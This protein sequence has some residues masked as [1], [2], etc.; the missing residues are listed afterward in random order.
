M[1]INDTIHSYWNNRAEGYSRRNRDEL[2]GQQG[3]ALE[4]LFADNLHPQPGA[5]ALDVGCGPGIFAITLAKLGCSVTGLDLSEEMLARAKANASDLGLS[6][7]FVQSDA[8]NPPFKAN[9]FDFIVN[10][11]M[12]WN[13]TT[14]QQA[15]RNWL[16]LLKPGG[17]L[18][19]LDGNHYL[20]HFDA[21]YAT[22]ESQS[23]PPEGHAPEYML[24]VDTSVIEKVAVDLPL[25]RVERPA[26]DIDQLSSLGAEVKIVSQSQSEVLVANKPE[27]V[28]TEFCLI[29][30]KPAT[31]K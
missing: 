11:Y 19:I 24:G 26:W 8:V 12:V 20:S 14:P 16:N 6:V 28:T 27:F 5:L 17:K 9:T 4:I 29:A 22:W 18:L 25:S 15:Y 1:T 23:A 7:D 13:L 30:T 2:N 3:R 21:R 10:R 31:H